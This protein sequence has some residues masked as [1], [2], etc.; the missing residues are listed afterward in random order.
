[1]TLEK[2]VSDLEKMITQLAYAQFKTEMML[3]HLT[4]EMKEFKDE[5]KEFKD[6]MKE[7]KDEMK[8]DRKYWAMQWG[9][10]ANKMGTLVEDLVL[11]G[12]LVAVVD[13]FNCKEEDIIFSGA[14]I[15]KKSQ[16]G[17]RR[18]FDAI[19]E[20]KEILIINETKS[21]LEKDHVDAF[22]SFI[23][24][25]DVLDFFPQA[26]AKTIIPIMSSLQIRKDV[27]DYLTEKEIFAMH[28]A[29]L[30]MRIVNFAEIQ[31]KQSPPR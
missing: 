4:D 26:N 20:C 19:V 3:Q 16:S 11:P 1:M 7:F 24:S 13:V 6:E 27:I 5:M 15:K 10:L 8:E 23:E 29:E 12:M 21:N 28:L 31:E 9:Q 30:E 25:N 14:R 17:K 18:E 2:K 22:K